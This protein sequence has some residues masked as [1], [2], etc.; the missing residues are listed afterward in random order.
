MIKRQIPTKASNEEFS[1]IS[2]T[3]YFAEIIIVRRMYP[4]Y[5]YLPD[6]FGKDV[7]C[8]TAHS[9]SLDGDVIEY[10]VFFTPLVHGKKQFSD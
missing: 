10:S 4:L 6:P 1:I 5:M 9:D 8:I 2:Q 7:K 3:L